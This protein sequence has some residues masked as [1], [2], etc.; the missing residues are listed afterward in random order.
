MTEHAQ[1]PGD[2]G[3]H[4]GRWSQ[5]RTQAL[6]LFFVTLVAVVLCIALVRPF[7]PAFAWAVALAVVA[8]PVHVG[9]RKVLPHRTLAAG[10]S[11][12]VV[13]VV[14]VV[15]AMLIALELTREA[16]VLSAQLTDEWT[17]AKW[18]AFLGGHPD[19]A[20]LL[21]SLQI[22]FNPADARAKAASA[23]MGSGLPS[24]LSQLVEW[25]VQALIAFFLLFYFFRDQSRFIRAMER[26]VPL[27]KR[28]TDQALHRIA[29]MLHATIYGTIAVSFI[30]GALGGLM[31]WW[32]DLPSPLLWG[33]VMGMLAI[34]PVLGAFIIWV[35][36]AV[37]LALTGDV[38]KA[39]ILTLWGGLVIGFIDNLL[40]PLFVGGRAHL[41]TVP[42]F[43]AIMGGLAMF[44]SAGMIVGPVILV[45]TVGLM[46]AWRQ[47]W[48]RELE[49]GNPGHASAASPSG[50]SP[51]G[52]ESRL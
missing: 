13:V 16:Y 47:R 19:F 41:H 27:P 34:V 21:D 18:Q 50:S 22:H 8:H 29:E 15:P 1:P 37:Y 52:S 45:V 43:I 36:A 20:S 26:M 24:F 6:I 23:A 31:F 42:V 49:A 38:G 39:V 9:I 10:A 51:S 32:L 35:P 30:Q 14:M 12:V 17:S 40:Y 33:V 11:V 4:A 5:E 48:D 7:L 3:H 44:G 25:V 28:E 46:H 2:P